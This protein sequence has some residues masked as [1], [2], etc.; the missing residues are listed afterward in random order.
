MIYLKT[1]ILFFCFKSHVKNHADDVMKSMKHI[2]DK[3]QQCIHVTHFHFIY[4]IPLFTFQS[5]ITYTW[6]SHK[7]APN[8]HTNTYLIIHSPCHSLYYNL[9]ITCQNHIYIYILFHAVLWHVNS[10]FNSDIYILTYHIEN[11][12]LNMYILHSHLAYT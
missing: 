6:W 12:I 10:H 4:I 8:Q 2:S 3:K 1:R 11:H 5:I 9:L 7:I